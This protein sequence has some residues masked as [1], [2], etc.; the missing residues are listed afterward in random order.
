MRTASFTWRSTRYLTDDSMVAEKNIVWRSFGVAP[1]I[2]WMLGRKPMSSMRSASSRTT[3]W[4]PPS[5]TRSRLMKSH[6]RPGV[7]I[8]TCA[9]LRTAVNWVFS[10]RPPTI[11]AERRPL[12]GA[13]LLKTSLIWMASSRVGLSTRAHA[14]FWCA[15]RS[16]RGSTKA[17]VLPVPVWA[18]ATTSRPANAGSI[19]WACTGVISVKP[20]FEILLLRGAERESS[21]NF[22]IQ[23]F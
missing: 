17:S 16:M 2:R 18:V 23:T 12:P 6:K 11:T 10:L 1:R 20:F 9:P 5:F 15:S 13:I 8:S 14:P 4:I 3:I 19:A 21:E 22:V 7:A